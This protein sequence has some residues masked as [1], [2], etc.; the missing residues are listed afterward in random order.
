MATK[1]NMRACT[2]AVALGLLLGA[3]CTTTQL[4]QELADQ[5]STI[6]AMYYEIVLNNLAM[7]AADPS[8][9]PYFSDP[10]TSRVQLDNVTNVNYSL[11]WDLITTAPTGVLTLFNRYL[12]DRQS[13][14][15]AGS[16]GDLHEWDAVTANDPDKLFTMRAAYRKTIGT[17]TDEDEEI[18]KEFYYRHFEVTKKGLEDIKQ[19]EPKVYQAVGE[20]L[21]KLVGVEYLS[22]ESFE[23]RLAEG[24]MLG[25]DDV[26]RY[27]RV[28]LKYTRME[29]EPT[30]FVSDQDTHHLLYI[31]ALKPGWFAVG[32]KCDVPKNAC[33]VGHYCDTYV[34]VPHEQLEVLTR[35]Y[36]GHPRHPHVQDRAHRR[37]ARTA[38]FGD[39]VTT[40][41]SAYICTS[42]AVTAGQF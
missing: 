20:K 12:L 21:Q 37:L 3:G 29:N 40:T 31:S 16:H 2:A 35:L 7:I 17:E 8:R 24:D 32:C 18:L 23:K 15:V 42:R 13:A 36:A 11:G 14:T 30:E 39:P 26:G 1:Q 34:W 19:K 41:G 22:V 9:M 25:Q 28:I 4:R 5:A 10:Q 38:R 6:P 33:Y 27:R